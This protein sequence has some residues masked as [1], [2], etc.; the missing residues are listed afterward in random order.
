MAKTVSVGPVCSYHGQFKGKLEGVSILEFLVLFTLSPLQT[1]DFQCVLT[2]DG[3]RSFV[4]FN[5]G[6]IQWTTGTAS[7]NVAAQVGFDSGNRVDFYNVNG[8]RTDAILLVNQ[9]SNVGVPGQFVFGIAQ[10][11][12][13]AVTMTSRGPTT[14]TTTERKTTTVL[15]STK[16]SEPGPLKRKP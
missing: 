5:Y 1:N 7:R 4:I 3:E 12:E 14:M 9:K 2:T 10:R 8:S 16:T 6:R 13:P 15:A 11:I